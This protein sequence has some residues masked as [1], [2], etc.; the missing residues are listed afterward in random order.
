MELLLATNNPKKQAELAAILK[1][2]GVRVRTQKELGLAVEV[3]ENGTTY[4]ENSALK[5]KALC[6]AS[7]LPAVADDSGLEVTA[8]GGRPGVYSARYGG[9][10][11]DDAQRTAL[12]LKEMEG[13]TDRGARFV[14]AIVCV[15]PDG[16]EPITARGECSGVLLREPK[17][18]GGFGYDPIFYVPEQGGT[19]SQIPAE[20]KN[21]ISHR[22]LA[23]QDFARKLKEKIEDADQ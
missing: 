12:L 23:L 14:S 6:S 13:Q 9:E 7:G 16:S 3:E 8:L 5:A 19:F 22:A 1:D 10:G 21:Q 11:L 2:L 15:F 18:D 17:G 4:E 20:V